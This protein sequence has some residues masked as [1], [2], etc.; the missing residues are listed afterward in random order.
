[1]KI[2]NADSKVVKKIKKI[3]RT[4]FCISNNSIIQLFIIGIFLAFLACNI[5][6]E[7]I[8]RNFFEFFYIMHYNRTIEL[9][10]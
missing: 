6:L 1:M 4:F 9:R 3:A 10:I 8:M 7:N 2:K 5:F